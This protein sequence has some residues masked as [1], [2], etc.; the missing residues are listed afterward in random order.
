MASWQHHLRRWA[1]AGL[2]DPETITRIEQ[3]EANRGDSAAGAV[4]LRWPVVVALSL[5]GVLLG[6]GV[7]L[8]VNAHWEELGPGSRLALILAALGGF[9]LGGAFTAASFPALAT[10]LHALGTVALGGAIAM[11]GQ[12]FHIEEHWPNAILLWAVGAGAGVLLLRTWPQVAALALL[13]PAWV[14]AEMSE[15]LP[16]SGMASALLLL[17]LC[18]AYMSAA[19]PQGN[20]TW[21]VCLNVIGTV[22]VL[23]CAV[24]V[25]LLQNSRVDITPARLILPAA[26]GV[27]VGC[28]LR[29]ELWWPNALAAIWALLHTVFGDT[30]HELLLYSWAGL[31]AVG[32]VA[33]GLYD[34]RV[35]RINVGMAGFGMT[36]LFFYFSNVLTALDRSL[37]LILL[38]ILFLAG[39]WGMEKL[40]RRLVAH[41]RGGSPAL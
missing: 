21:R 39:G 17:S 24:M 41:V 26:A 6:A 18:F 12:I 3:F 11:T 28:L 30:R 9:H 16:A 23:V 29:R 13:A 33:W 31:G 22:A 5:G 10:T 7:L 2:V 38:G 25:P 1:D 34:R 32:M 15:R 4:G 14:V 35:E 19:R 37:A 40:R 20:R 27:A 8:F 36:V